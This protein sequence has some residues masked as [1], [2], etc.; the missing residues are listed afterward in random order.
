MEHLSILT[1]IKI[2]Y[3]HNTFTFLEF[4]IQYLTKKNVLV[5]KR[6]KARFELLTNRFV[7]NILFHRDTFLGSDVG[8]IFFYKIILSLYCCIVYF[9][10]TPQY[11]GFP[12]HLKTTIYLVF[13]FNLD[14]LTAVSILTY[15]D[16]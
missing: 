6:G 15:F 12:Y 9:D 11:G 7:V 16:H 2:H 14:I 4:S 8:E 13:L 1:W 5:F 3:N 10:S